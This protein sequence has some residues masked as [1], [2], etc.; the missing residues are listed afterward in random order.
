MTNLTASTNF[1]PMT[2]KTRMYYETPPKGITITGY[3]V[4]R[5]HKT[6]L[7]NSMTDLFE[8]SPPKALAQFGIYAV[9]AGTSYGPA[10]YQPR[11]DQPG[12]VVSETDPETGAIVTVKQEAR[13]PHYSFSYRVEM[14]NGNRITGSEQILGTRVG[15]RGLGMPAPS[16]FLFESSTGYKATA[17][18]LIS[19]EL[20]PGLGRW[21]VRGYAELTIE[22]NLGNQGQITLDR[23]GRLKIVVNSPDGKEFSK[24]DKL[25]ELDD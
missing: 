23:K 5:M 12:S 4:R 20:A 3:I 19:S 8:N 6:R 7:L 17:T 10:L 16:N 24:T 14:K 25:S 15:L 11:F 2:G 13:S 21:R 18:G 22:D 9:A 1:M